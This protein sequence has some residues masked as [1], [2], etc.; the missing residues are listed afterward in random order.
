MD[1]KQRVWTGLR[2]YQRD[3]SDRYL[4]GNNRH[5]V[6]SDYNRKWSDPSQVLINQGPEEGYRFVNQAKSLGLPFN[7]GDID[8]AAVDF[9]NDGRS[10]WP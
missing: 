4:P 9:D 1:G 8:A 2:G 6:A 3:D 5:P 7:E 10:I